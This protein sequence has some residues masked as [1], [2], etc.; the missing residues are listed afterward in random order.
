[1]SRVVTIPEAARSPELGSLFLDY[2]LSERGQ[3][4][5]T[6]AAGLQGILPAGGAQGEELWPLSDV[7]GPVNT[8]T[9]GPA[10]LVFLDPLKKGRFLAD[11]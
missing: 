3:G 4:V 2:L 1:M 6:A 5:V 7:T 11:W 10:L 8:I 9:L